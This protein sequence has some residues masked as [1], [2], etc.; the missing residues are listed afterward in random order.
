MSDMD[1]INA[2]VEAAQEAYEQADK[3]PFDHGFA[4][5]NG[6]DGRTK[7]ASLLKQHDAIECDS[8]DHVTISGLSRY[9]GPQRKGYKAFLS[10]LDEHGVDV[11]DVYVSARLD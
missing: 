5:L 10:T 8:W 6:I 11:S 1:A 7:F 2:A 4:N 3:S 9:C